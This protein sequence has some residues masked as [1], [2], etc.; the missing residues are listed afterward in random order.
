MDPKPFGVGG[1]HVSDDRGQ[2]WRNVTG[3]LWDGTGLDW[4]DRELHKIEFI[5]SGESFDA[6]AAIAVAGQAGVRVMALDDEGTWFNAG[7]GPTQCA[8][9]GS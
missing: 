2:T 3:N 5:P 4:P 1:V 8:G 9:V 6:S 7:I